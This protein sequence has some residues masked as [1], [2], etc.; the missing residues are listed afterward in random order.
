MRRYLKVSPER[1]WPI[2]ALLHDERGAVAWVVAAVLAA[3]VTSGALAVD[4]GMAYV[5]RSE[6]QRVADA[7]ALAG[8]AA[9]IEVPGDV[10]RARRIAAEVAAGN[11]VRNKPVTLLP[12]DIEVSTISLTVHVR[13]LASRDEA[14]ETWFS[15][16]L[17]SGTIDVSARSR[18]S[19]TGAGGSTCLKPFIVPD[20]WHDANGNGRYDPGELYDPHVTGYG[21]GFRNDGFVRDVGR[22]VLLKP[23]S[24]SQAMVPNWYFLIRLPGNKGGADIRDEIATSECNPTVL[25][26]GEDMQVEQETGNMK[27]PV[28]QGVNALI[29]SDPNAYW[30]AT[31]GS[32]KG[33]LWGDAAWR[34]SPRVINIALFDPRQPLDPSTRPIRI[35]NFAT[36]FVERTSG[37]DIV[38]RFVTTMGVA[39][40]DCSATNTCAA[41]AKT[42]RLTN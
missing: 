32:V 42:V 39:V 34:A 15:R 36:V 24:N 9:L 13:R 27:G 19:V 11:A 10:G 5:A 35:S 29:A 23:G 2:G 31:T 38:G 14:L 18:A 28:R 12:E 4:L 22:Q 8:A 17:G 3:M 30:D 37:D 21:N 7:A 20:L 41:F 25:T 16:A 1:A 33:S 6:A 26:F 40:G